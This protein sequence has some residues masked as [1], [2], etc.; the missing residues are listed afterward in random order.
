MFICVKC[1][2][3]Y[4]NNNEINFDKSHKAKYYYGQRV[5]SS[6][7][8]LVSITKNCSIAD[9]ASN[10]CARE[11][12]KLTTITQGIWIYYND[13]LHNLTIDISA[14][15]GEGYNGENRREL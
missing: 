1:L 7:T 3:Y 9:S 4:R 12:V 13:N 2:L 8:V 11:G 5:N 14:V 10:A 6:I 15:V